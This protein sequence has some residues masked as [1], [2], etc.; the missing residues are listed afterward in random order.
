MTS[1]QGS[2]EVTCPHFRPVTRNRRIVIFNFQ[3][4]DVSRLLHHHLRND[5][6]AAVAYSF[7]N[8]VRFT[9]SC[10]KSA[11]KSRRPTKWSV[12][13][14]S[15]QLPSALPARH[16]VH[17]YVIMRPQAESSLSTHLSLLIQC[18]KNVLPHL[19]RFQ[20]CFDSH[21]ST[22]GTVDFVA[23]ENSFLRP[24]PLR[25]VPRLGS[26]VNH[27]FFGAM[28]RQPLKFPEHLYLSPPQTPT[29][30]YSYLSLTSTYS[31]SAALFQET[32]SNALAVSDRIPGFKTSAGKYFS[33]ARDYVSYAKAISQPSSTPCAQTSPSQ[34]TLHPPPSQTLLTPCALS[35]WHPLPAPSLRPPHLPIRRITLK[36]RQRNRP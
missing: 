24:C 11:P 9:S 2:H 30:A 33:C 13:S 25:A 12:E 29:S 18:L 17:T 21:C 20:C 23:E 35:T 36:N 19:I 1:S 22:C 8:R 5:R 16:G 7:R 31:S 27:H 3:A 26:D 32:S 14:L 15:P 10:S 4:R 6:F 34:T 28:R